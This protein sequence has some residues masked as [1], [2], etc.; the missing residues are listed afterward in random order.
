MPRPGVSLRHRTLAILLIVAA[1]AVVAGVLLARGDDDGGGD[2]AAVDVTV[3][4]QPVGPVVAGPPGLSIEWDG[5]RRLTGPPGD[6]D[7]AFAALVR[8]L[9]AA[10]GARPE[11]RVGGNS[12]DQSWWNPAGDRRPP[13][14]LFDITPATLD[15]LAWLARRTGARLTLG[16][17]LALGDDARDV[18]FVR[19]ARRRLPR[20]ALQG[21]EVGNE[22][23]LYA[24]AR[25]FRVGPLVLRRVRK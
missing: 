24:S 3:T 5:I 19:A 15:D 21:L 16:V 7:E 14:I 6:R 18:A 20:G 23:D 22:P 9:G 25:T 8:R 2:R 13:T 11:I 17:N 4:A 10:A 12:T 1:A